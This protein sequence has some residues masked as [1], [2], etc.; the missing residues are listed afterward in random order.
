M[1]AG[2][3]AGGVVSGL[4]VAN[5]FTQKP[6]HA[7]HAAGDLG[8]QLA[9]LERKKSIHMRLFRLQH[10]LQNGCATGIHGAPRE[11]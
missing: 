5:D 7:P 2:H 8:F 10:H 11:S 3:A 9:R 4:G 1:N 6:L